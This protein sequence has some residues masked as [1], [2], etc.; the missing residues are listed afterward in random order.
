[1]SSVMAPK[2]KAAVIRKLTSLHNLFVGIVEKVS[3][4]KKIGPLRLKA[5]SSGS[6]EGWVKVDVEFRISGFL[7]IEAMPPEAANMID[8]LFATVGTKAEELVTLDRKIKLPE[9]A[10]DGGGGTVVMQME[11]QA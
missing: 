10:D 6:K 7:P 1:M 5:L 3:K 4:T 11:L 9:M 2:V 8:A